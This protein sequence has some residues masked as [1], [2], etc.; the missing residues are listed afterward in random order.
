MRNLPREA[1]PLH[2]YRTGKIHPSVQG[3]SMS[4]RLLRSRSR[5]RSPTPSPVASASSRL[6]QLI[7]GCPASKVRLASL[8]FVWSPVSPA[9]PSPPPALRLPSS[10][11]PCQSSLPP[12][13]SSK[14][15]GGWDSRRLRRL[16]P[17][18]QKPPN[19][20]FPCFGRA[21]V[22]P[23]ESRQQEVFSSPGRS[24]ASAPACSS[25]SSS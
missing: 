21:K 4:P 22:A 8:L 23:S 15:P 20:N 16:R 25:W 12:G 2:Y 24:S 3:H 19:K 7:A 17:H 1:I 6:C 11:P 14:S 13:S 10:S 5:S 18:S 9:S